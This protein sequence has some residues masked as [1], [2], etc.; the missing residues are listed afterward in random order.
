MPDVEQWK[1]LDPCSPFIEDDKYYITQEFEFDEEPVST[2]DEEA[3]EGLPT[4]TDG[5]DWE[6]EIEDDNGLRGK[7]DLIVDDIANVVVKVV[8]GSSNVGDT[9]KVSQIGHGRYDWKTHPLTQQILEAL[10]QPLSQTKQVEDLEFKVALLRA[11]KAGTI[12]LIKFYGKQYDDSAEW[13]AQEV[14]EKLHGKI[15]VEDY[16][17]FDSSD[18]PPIALI[19]VNKEAFDSLTDDPEVCSIDIPNPAVVVEYPLS[20]LTNKIGL[21]ASGMEILL[22]TLAEAGIFISNVNIENEIERLAFGAGFHLQNYFNLNNIQPT[23]VVNEECSL[24][25]EDSKNVTL[26]FDVD[27]KL[28]YILIDNE[29]HTLGYDCLLEQ[30]EFSHITTMHYLT[31]L[32]QMIGDLKNREDDDFSFFTFL[33]VHTLPKIIIGPKE[34]DNDG[35]NQYDKNGNFSPPTPSRKGPSCKTDDELALETSKINQPIQKLSKAQSAK[36]ETEHVG[37]EETSPSAIEKTVQKLQG[38]NPSNNNRSSHSEPKNNDLLSKQ[39]ISENDELGKSLYADVDFAINDVLAKIDLGKMTQQTI[40]NMLKDMVHN[41]GTEIQEDPELQPAFELKDKSE[42]LHNKQEKFG[43]FN[44][45]AAGPVL[46]ELKLPPYF[47]NDKDF[48]KPAMDELKTNVSNLVLKETITPLLETLQNYTDFNLSNPN[49]VK[50]LYARNSS[51]PGTQF[52]VL[53]SEA[54]G[55]NLEN[56]S[57]SKNFASI[58][59]T[60]GGKGFSGI[61]SNILSKKSSPSRLEISEF[62]LSDIPIPEGM[63]VTIEEAGVLKEKYLKQEDL[64]SITDEISTGVDELSVILKPDEFQSLLKGRAPKNIV[65]L[66]TKVLTRNASH[67]GIVFK[68]KQDVVDI[69]AGIGKILNPA[70][71]AKSNVIPDLPISTDLPNENL[72]SLR[73]QLLKEQNPILSDKQIDEIIEKEK[74]RKKERVLKAVETL[75]RYT[76]GELLPPMPPLFGSKGLIKEV[77]PVI[78]EVA[79]STSATLIDPVS[80]VFSEKISPKLTSGSYVDFWNAALANNYLVNAPNI[81]YNNFKVEAKNNKYTFGYTPNTTVSDVT[82]PPV[83]TKIKGFDYYF[84]VLFG[85]NVIDDDA[86]KLYNQAEREFNSFVTK[87]FY[88]NSIVPQLQDMDTGLGAKTDGNRVDFDDPSSILL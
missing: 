20:E 87:N 36:V 29:K 6:Y 38:A 25:E 37:A 1:Y 82:D 2:S 46:Q 79:E 12:K 83:R 40:P 11:A 48:L 31:R 51:E 47:P 53:L 66:S 58:L 67:D 72:L 43:S 49:Q 33:E 19:S 85:D 80:S 71:L 60:R 45:N 28:R 61:I 42:A 16:Y 22:P 14:Q 55:I 52:K 41:Y 15:K 62:N 64:M 8:D 3:L 50:E 65:D 63:P 78:K 68:N 21:V 57:D 34:N 69:M 76:N 44:I 54:S 88:D 18:V 13:S 4:L 10:S 39:Q 81:I 70:T 59:N 84:N 5:R 56:I 23:R 17:F 30:S 73:A 86:S 7:E 77:P 9:F 26:G 27:Y 75:E 74:N 32:D 24:P 35:V